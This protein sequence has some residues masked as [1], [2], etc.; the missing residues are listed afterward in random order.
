MPGPIVIVLDASSHDGSA[1]ALA[2]SLAKR[3]GVAVHLTEVQ[4]PSQ[5]GGQIEATNRGSGRQGNG[6]RLRQLVDL[7]QTNGVAAQ[8]FIP[9]GDVVQGIMRQIE[10]E[11]ASLVITVT[12]TTPTL[13]RVF[14]D[15]LAD[16]LIRFA[17][18]PVLVC[19]TNVLERPSIDLRRILVAL[20]G[21]EFAEHALRA[22][23]VFGTEADIV[24]MR[25]ISTSD[26]ELLS[27]REPL[28]AA[29]PSFLANQRRI[30]EEYLNGVADL[31]I[32]DG[33]RVSVT[34]SEGV[35]PGRT[36]VDESVR[37]K[38]DLLALTT[39]GRT[40]FARRA[41]GSCAADVLRLAPMP[42]L[43][44]GPNLVRSAAGQSGASEKS[45]AWVG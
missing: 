22:V 26:S 41:L 16:T 34:V 44:A 29:I 42:V 24:L 18:A 21:S 27:S 28:A 25:A 31:L 7:C 5:D 10:Q 14:S 6:F 35:W 32:A 37:Q 4:E 19:S 15:N 43:I 33:L 36:I 30:A 1:V 20:D 39:H 8:A 17:T 45:S 38:I 40:G 13:R 23:R 2:I 11:H 3:A 9:D 12:R